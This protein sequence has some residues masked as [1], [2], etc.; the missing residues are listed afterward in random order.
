MNE[1]EMLLR[2]L[3]SAQFAAFELHLFLDTH[4]NDAEALSAIRKYEEKAAA[5]RA[6]FESKFGPLQAGDTYGDT[7]WKWLSDPWPWDIQKEGM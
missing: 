1:R 4:P 2:R 3:S 5:L 7:S 6:E